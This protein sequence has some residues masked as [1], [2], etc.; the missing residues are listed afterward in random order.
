MGRTRRLTSCFLGGVSL[1]LSLGMPTLSSQIACIVV[2]VALII[3]GLVSDE[4]LRRI[5][6][7][8]KREWWEKEADEKKW[9]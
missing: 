9:K 7:E 2:G 3:F 6:A 5:R 4:K 1:R 8:H